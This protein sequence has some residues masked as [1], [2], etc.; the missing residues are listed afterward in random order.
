M[1]HVEVLRIGGGRRV[2][3]E[4]E[5]VEWESGNGAVVR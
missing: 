1:I 2:G 3:W 4:V 5:I